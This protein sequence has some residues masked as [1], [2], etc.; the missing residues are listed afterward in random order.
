MIIYV[1]VCLWHFYYYFCTISLRFLLMSHH[2]I[3]YNVNVILLIISHSEY[4]TYSVGTNGVIVMRL[5]CTTK[6]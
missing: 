2:V 6:F 3:L 1:Y 4:I 5:E